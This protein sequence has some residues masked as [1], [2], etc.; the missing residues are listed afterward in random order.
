[1]LSGQQINIEENHYWDKYKNTKCTNLSEIKS[2][3]LSSSSFEFRILSRSLLCSDIRSDKVII[4]K[5]HKNKLK[6]SLYY[7]DK[8]HWDNDHRF[9][10]RKIKPTEYMR[11]LFNE[12]ENS[13]LFTSIYSCDTIFDIKPKSVNGFS[14]PFIYTDDG[15][16]YYLELKCLD[17]IYYRECSNPESNYTVLVENFNFPDN[18]TAI[19][20]YKGF[21]DL[22]RKL[23]SELEIEI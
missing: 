18:Q 8:E 1:M 9:I 7:A 12:I 21:T 10:E 20:F 13:H 15:V 11:Y 14:L 6:C 4:I 3:E 19:D 5:K 2:I 16:S 23:R 22:L 17:N